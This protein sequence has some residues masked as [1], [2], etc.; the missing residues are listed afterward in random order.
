MWVEWRLVPRSDRVCVTIDHELSYPVPL[1][2]PLFAH[3]IVGDLFVHNIAGKT[4]RCLKV[5]VEAEE[6]EQNSR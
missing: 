3:F 5:R 2:G 1:L 6:A 4:L